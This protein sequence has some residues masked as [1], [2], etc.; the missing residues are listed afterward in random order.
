MAVMPRVTS[1]TPNTFNKV[2]Q[3][4]V[5]QASGFVKPN[6]L[7]ALDGASHARSPPRT[8]WT[9]RRKRILLSHYRVG[10]ELGRF[11]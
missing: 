4:G 10:K 3:A 5:C 7:T 9:A 8:N 6:S 2:L 11:V 1:A